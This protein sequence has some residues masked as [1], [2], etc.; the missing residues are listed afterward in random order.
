VIK[1]WIKTRRH[2]KNDF[3]EKNKT[4]NEDARRAWQKTTQS[5]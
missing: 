5:R 1:P 2:G 3:K 4:E